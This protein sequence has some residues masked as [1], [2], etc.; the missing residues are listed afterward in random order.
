[1]IKPFCMNARVRKKEN[2]FCN[3]IL[4]RIIN[5]L[6]GNDLTCSILMFCRVKRK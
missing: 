3:D 2:K 6:K 5:A 4:I 1:M